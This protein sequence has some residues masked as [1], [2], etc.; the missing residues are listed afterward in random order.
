[1]TAYQPNDGSGKSTIGPV[2]EGFDFLGCSI[3]NNRVAPSRDATKSLLKKI[4]DALRE[5]ER[6]IKAFASGQLPT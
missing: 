6:S 3:Q 5:G 1:M 2:S 4:R